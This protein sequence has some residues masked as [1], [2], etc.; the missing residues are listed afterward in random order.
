MKAMMIEGYK[1]EGPY[2]I[3]KDDIPEV[4]GVALIVSEAGEGTKILCVESGDNLHISLPNSP[5]LPDWKAH[6]F[7]EIADAY[8]LRVDDASQ[9]QAIVDKIIYK[10]KA[11]LVC[12]KFAPIVDDW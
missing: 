4:S 1:F 6:S 3:E 5:E 11:S 2:E 7:H 8:I 12:Q 10:R 9:R